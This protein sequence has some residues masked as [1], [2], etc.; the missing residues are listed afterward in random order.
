MASGSATVA[1]PEDI[2]MAVFCRM[3]SAC[4]A[5][6]DGFFC[7]VIATMPATC[8]EAIDVPLE[9]EYDVWPFCN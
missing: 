4:A 5:V 9:K 7:V 6:S 3:L 1:Q 2:R 8:G